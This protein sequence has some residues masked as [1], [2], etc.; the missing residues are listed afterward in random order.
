MNKLKSKSKPQTAKQ[1]AA[2][3][4]NFIKMRVACAFH[5]LYPALTDPQLS[6]VNRTIITVAQ[7]LIRTAL[8]DWEHR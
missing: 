8:N 6:K 1:R 5:Q 3:K 4:H 2:T 7:D